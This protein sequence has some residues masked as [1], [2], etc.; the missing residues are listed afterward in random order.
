[1]RRDRRCGSKQTVHDGE[2]DRCRVPVR[3][4]LGMEVL[5]DGDEKFE[6]L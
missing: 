6:T 3:I 5:D 2:G 4:V 1:M